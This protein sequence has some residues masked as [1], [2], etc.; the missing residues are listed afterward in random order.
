MELLKSI[1]IKKGDIGYNNNLFGGKLFY[2]IDELLYTKSCELSG[3]K[4]MMTKYSEFTFNYPVKEGEII[5]IYLE[6]S[7]VKNS[8]IVFHVKIVNENKLNVL[9]S[10]VIFVK[11]ES[12]LKSSPIQSHL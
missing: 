1:S 11:V 6:S 7:E 10:K 4:Y 5:N 8:S 9:E 12:K 2:W 3:S